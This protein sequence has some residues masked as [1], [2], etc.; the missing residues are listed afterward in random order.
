MLP[1]TSSCNNDENH[2]DLCS[3]IYS[4]Y[5]EVVEVIR[6]MEYELNELRVKQLNKDLFGT[7]VSSLTTSFSILISPW[8]LSNVLRSN[9]GATFILITSSIIM[10]TY[11]K[12]RTFL[13]VEES[14]EIEILENVVDWFKKLRNAYEI[15]LNACNRKH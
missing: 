3:L 15:M 13:G 6:I 12:L 14:N 9:N 11:I 4:K 10:L 5:M 8:I 1:D 2:H 7:S